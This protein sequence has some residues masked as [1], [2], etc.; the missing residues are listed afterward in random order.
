MSKKTN[1]KIVAL[2]AISTLACAGLG[3]NA[4]NAPVSA[5]ADSTIAMVTGASVRLA[6]DFYG[7]RFKMAVSTEYYAQNSAGAYGMLII[8]EDYLTTYETQLTAGENDYVKV[9]GGIQKADSEENIPL[10]NI[11]NMTGYSADDKYEATTETAT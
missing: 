8:P 9:L 11:T 7:L 5:K 6:D 10:L 4:I 3:V 1:K 2:L